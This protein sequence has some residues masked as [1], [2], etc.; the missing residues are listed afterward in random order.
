MLRNGEWGTI[1]D[2]SITQYEL[3]VVCGMLNY[4]GSHCIVDHAGF[5]SGAGN[6][7]G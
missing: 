4:T 5:G 2:I 3:N 7:F 6:F 1:C